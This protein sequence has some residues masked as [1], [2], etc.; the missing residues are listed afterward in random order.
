MI[1][2]LYIIDFRIVM[3]TGVERNI[4]LGKTY[5]SSS[6]SVL[7]FKIAFKFKKM[8]CKMKL[9]LQTT[10]NCSYI[11]HLTLWEETLTC[12][13]MAM[14][15]DSASRSHQKLYLFFKLSCFIEETQCG[16]HENPLKQHLFG[17]LGRQKRED[18]EDSQP[19]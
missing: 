4:F 19:T 15:W 10:L 6:E 3:V 12:L 18:V 7:K 2:L 14:W 16:Q 17:L 1:S 9:V 5:I 8:F 11:F 13:F